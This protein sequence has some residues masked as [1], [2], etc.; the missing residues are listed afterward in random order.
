MNSKSILLLPVL[1][2]I[3]GP[4]M[5]KG[6]LL[7]ASA[8][9]IPHYDQ[10]QEGWEILFDGSNTDK[11]RSKDSSAFP[12]SGWEVRDGMLFL[13]ERGGGDII[14]K[15][16]YGNFVLVLDFRLTPEANSGI[17]YFVGKLKDRQTGETVIN[18]PEYQ[19]ID[20]YNNPAVK[21]HRHDIGSTASCYLLYIPK[22]KKLNPAGQWNRMKIIAK[23]TYVEHWLNGV[24]VLSYERGSADF[25]KRKSGTKF[26]NLENYGTLPAGHI[27]ITDHGDKVYFRDIKIRRL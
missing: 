18:G 4:V 11:W 14:T 8:D 5:S 24:K 10:K 2:L 15:E 23:G 6:R 27:L 25:M 1:F 17:K 12:S 20:D 16:E 3:W 13:G 7:H 22:N 19:I 9:T 21:D 26:R